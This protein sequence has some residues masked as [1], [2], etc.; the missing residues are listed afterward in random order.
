MGFPTGFAAGSPPA[1]AR[2][3]WSIAAAALISL[4]VG[5]CGPCPGGGLSGE[6]ATSLPAD[7]S[8]SD[9][10][11]RCLVELGTTDGPYSITTSCW[12]HDGAL[13]VPAMM[14]ERKRWTRIALERPDVRIQ[15]GDTV[16]PLHAER[17]VDETER[18]AAFR[19]GYRK[20]HDG[21]SPPPDWEVPDDRWVFRMVPRPTT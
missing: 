20:Y 10:H 12:V 18:M 8:F 15:I 5:P 6:V 1:R 14:A 13:H 16:F 3:L 4:A 2:S 7:W 19:A 21:E 9:A 11:S 17:I